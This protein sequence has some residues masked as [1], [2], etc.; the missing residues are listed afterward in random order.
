MPHKSTKLIAE[1]LNRNYQAVL[2][3]VHK[4][5]KTAGNSKIRLEDVIEIDEVYPH[6][7][8]KGFKKRIPDGEAGTNVAGEL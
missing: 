4:V 5:Q 3:F 8:S 7:G 6:T 1:E 2:N